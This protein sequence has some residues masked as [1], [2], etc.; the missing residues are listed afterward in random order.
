MFGE[1]DDLPD[2]LRVVGERAVQRLHH[3]VRLSAD[4]DDALHVW[5][6]ER[7]QGRKHM[8][9]TLFPPEHH[10]F[11]SSCRRHLKFPVAK[12][13]RLLAVASKKVSETR[14]RIAGNV[15]NQSGDGVR[16]GIKRGE[17]ILVFEL[18]HG[19]F[20][21]ALVPAELTL[22]FFE[23]LVCEVSHKIELCSPTGL[24]AIGLNSNWMPPIWRAAK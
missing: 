24:G 14:A 3:G 23:V 13:V 9:P 11:A 19:G 5:G 12:S 16:F 18:S 8:C 17:E 15:L 20:A 10:F 2:V 7:I 6:L 21:H 22:H 1:K 4:G